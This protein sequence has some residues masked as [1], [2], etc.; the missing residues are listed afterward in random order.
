MALTDPAFDGPA[1]DTSAVGFGAAAEAQPVIDAPAPERATQPNNILDPGFDLTLRPMRYPQFFDMYRD[2]IKNTWTVDEIDLSDLDN[3][4]TPGRASPGQP[5]GCVLRYRRLDR[6]QQPGAE[7][8]HAHQC[9]RSSHVPVTPALR[10]SAA[11]AVLP[12][13]ARQL[14]PRHG[15]APSSLSLRSRTSRRSSRR[16]TSASST[17]AASTVS[18]ELNTKDERRQ[19][20]M[21][22]ICF[23]HLHRGPVLLRS[24]CLRVLPALQGLLNGS[25]DWHQL[26]LPHMNF[27]LEV[28]NTVRAEEP[29]LIDDAMNQRI[30]DMIGEAVD[31]E[32]LFAEDLLSEGVTGMSLADT[33]TYLEFV[34]R[35]ALGHARLATSLRR[36]E[37]VCVHGTAR[38]SAA[39]ELLRAHRVV[40]PSWHRRNGSA[41]SQCR[42]LMYF[43]T[44]TSVATGSTIR[45]LHVCSVCRLPFCAI[46]PVFELFGRL[47]DRGWDNQGPNMGTAATNHDDLVAKRA[48]ARHVERHEVASSREF[49]AKVTPKTQSPSSATCSAA[50]MSDPRCEAGHAGEYRPRPDGRPNKSGP[51]KP[52]PP[53]P[54]HIA[55]KP[56]TRTHAKPHRPRHRSR[57]D[58]LSTAPPSRASLQ[59]LRHAGDRPLSPSTSMVVYRATSQCS[60][61]RSM[62]ASRPL[63][64]PSRSAVPRSYKTVA[65]SV[66]A[67]RLGTPPRNRRQ[68]RPNGSP[69]ARWAA[70][71]YVRGGREAEG[72]PPYEARP[73]ETLPES[74]DFASATSDW[75][76]TR[77]W[78]IGE[79]K[80]ED[81][82]LC[83]D[84]LPGWRAIVEVKG[85]RK[86]PRTSDELVQKY[87][88]TV[89]PNVHDEAVKFDVVAIDTPATVP[90]EERHNRR[91]CASYC[92]HSEVP[93]APWREGQT[94]LQPASC[95]GAR[96]EITQQPQE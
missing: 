57:H 41:Q 67:T 23:R 22:L 27:A 70:R 96:D 56:P 17:W 32:Y 73:M 79:A 78:T 37:P 95:A 55:P 91:S 53:P 45:L 74:T 75:I 83:I 72:P 31:C 42:A 21:N 12:D 84:S 19:F 20:L 43:S 62:T 44:S 40:V 48:V 5:S 60:K 10:R 15:R 47:L 46:C 66:V 1:F 81:F 28:V 52:Q 25:A 89:G 54:P 18:T 7:P 68:P 64:P 87:P 34:G 2:A 63:P 80:A 4:L 94:A 77:S 39:L 3:K 36:R 35:P 58:C 65:N 85:Y 11:R 38:R 86:E 76:R 9:A 29:D 24:V 90:L 59:S 14:H 92:Q 26:G 50:P 88:E 49:V 33:R 93:A 30:S 51:S 71:Y 13:A 6:G 16:L 69:Q 61:L 8:V 82:H